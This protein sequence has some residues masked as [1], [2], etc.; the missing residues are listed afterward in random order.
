MISCFKTEHTSTSDVEILTEISRMLDMQ[1]LETAELIHQYYV[2]KY[3]YQRNMPQ[4]KYGQLTIRG[5][6]TDSSELLVN[7][8]FSFLILLYYYYLFISLI[9]ICLPILAGNT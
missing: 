3:E 7:F 5:K 9:N 4:P 2:E 1:A 8:L 6:F